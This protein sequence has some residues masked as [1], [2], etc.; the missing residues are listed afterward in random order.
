MVLWYVTAGADWDDI[1]RLSQGW[2]N[3]YE[4]ALARQFVA[5]LDQSEGKSTKAT[6]RLRRLYWEIKAEGDQ[7]SKLAT[8]LRELWAK[9]PVLGL[10]ATEGIPTTPKAPSLACRLE[11]STHGVEAKLAASHPSGSESIPVG[12]F[13]IKATDEILASAQTWR[14]HCRAVTRTTCSH[15]ALARAQ[16]KGKESFRVKII[17]ASPMMLNGLVLGGPKPIDDTPPAVLVGLSIPPLKSLTIGASPDLVKRLHLKEGT[18]VLATDL[19][20]L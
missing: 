17:N 18:R 10:T 5:T 7:A 20:G 19:S 6:R 2:G 13:K 4:I 11:I 16:E 3:A 15:P 1:G 9:H 12:T 8:S 14:R